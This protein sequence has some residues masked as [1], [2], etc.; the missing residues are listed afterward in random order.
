MSCILIPFFIRYSLSNASK[1]AGVT[2]PNIFLVPFILSFSIF[3]SNVCEISCTNK[4][5]SSI[6]PFNGT[7]ITALLPL[8]CT[9]AT[10]E[11][12][13]IPSSSFSS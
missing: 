6:F 9:E 8:L 4:Y 1:T 7:N 5:I 2:S 10:L 11:Y 13:G 12:L 3:K